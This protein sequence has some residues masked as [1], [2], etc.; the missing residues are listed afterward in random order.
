MRISVLITAAAA[1]LASSAA[2]GADMHVRPHT[3]YASE[4]TV[5]RE[6]TPPPPPV[7]VKRTV[8]TTT[9]TTYQSNPHQIGYAETEYDEAPPRRPVRY[10]ETRF[11]PGPVGGAPVYHRPHRPWWA[12]RHHGHGRSF[13]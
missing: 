9:T 11:V 6:I 5:V 1:G 2:L 13:Y 8:T 12:W 7:V 10:S 3:L 4:T